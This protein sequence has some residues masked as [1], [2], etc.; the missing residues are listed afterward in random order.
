MKS[1]NDISGCFFEPCHIEAQ[2][3]PFLVHERKSLLHRDRF[4]KNISETEKKGA[5]DSEK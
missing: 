5:S 1:I 3:C 4:T 2:V